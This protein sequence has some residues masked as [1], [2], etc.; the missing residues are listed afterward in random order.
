MHRN[1]GC[2][3]SSL[4][5]PKQ[6]ALKVYLL[7]YVKCKVSITT[8]T[9]I[10]T[11]TTVLVFPSHTSQIN[12]LFVHKLTSLVLLFPTEF[13]A[14]IL[15]KYCSPLAAFIRSNVLLSKQPAVIHLRDDPF[16]YCTTKCDLGRHSNPGYSSH[17]ICFVDCFSTG[18]VGW[19]G[20]SVDFLM[21]VLMERICKYYFI[22]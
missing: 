10:T 13:M 5:S 15:T 20:T 22:A 21:Q 14:K 12:L 8:T 16:L 7:V 3:Q 1:G 2:I 18:I 19:R 4:R 6:T 9:M 17:V 11:T